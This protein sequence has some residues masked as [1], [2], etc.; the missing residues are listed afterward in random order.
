MEPK[1]IA[2]P[3]ILKVS[4][5]LKKREPIFHHPEYGT[6]REDFKNMTEE[7]FWEV[8][9]SG[10][11]YSREFIL[12]TLEKRFQNPQNEQWEIQDFNCMKLSENNYLATYTLIQDKVRTTRRSTLWKKYKD[13]WKIVYHQGTMVEQK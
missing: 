11:C 12:D 4:Q 6:S 1:L 2:D 5:E 3:E 8:E 9:A 10:K 7:T 13:D